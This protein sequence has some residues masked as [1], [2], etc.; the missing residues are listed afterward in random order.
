MGRKPLKDEPAPSI[1]SYI[2]KA[3]QKA[4]SGNK[5]AAA[6]KTSQGNICRLMAYGAPGDELVLRLAE[7][8]GEDPEKL[9]LL[10]HAE[11]APEKAQ[12][13]WARLLKKHVPAAAAVLAIAVV[14]GA[15]ALP[16]PG[17]SHSCSGSMYIM[18]N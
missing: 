9:L 2:E 4:G 8:L 15:T 7:Y 5:A 17:V 3:V 6:L 11:Y 1:K 13:V 14:A 16:F 12:P 18:S 10:A